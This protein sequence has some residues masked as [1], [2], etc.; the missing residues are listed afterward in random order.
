MVKRSITC[1]SLLFIG[2]G[3]SYFC[4]DKAYNITDSS[5]NELLIDKYFKNEVK[6]NNKTEIKQNKLSKE[7]YI[8]VLQIPKI[9]F[10]R[11][12]YKESSPENRLSK[13]IIFLNS[14]D[15]PDKNNSRVII[16][17]HSGAP[18][19][20]Y[21]KNLYK[22]VINDKLILYYD[23]Y[24]YTYKVTDI[25]EIKKTGTLALESNK[26]AKTLTL[27]TCKGLDRQIVIVSTLTKEEK[28]I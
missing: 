9:D 4:V 18:S 16:V 20:A 17:G 27:V 13:N 26:G 24:K 7:E 15:M 2:C 5:N 25:Y 3:I 12:L 28:L 8:A 21:F 11:G 10:K 1:I 19:N 14:S 23:N 6:S 22:L